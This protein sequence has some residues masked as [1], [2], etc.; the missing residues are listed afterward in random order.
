MLLKTGEGLYGAFDLSI[1][2]NP[3]R[4]L[5]Y[6]HLIHGIKKFKLYLSGYFLYRGG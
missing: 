5:L 4:K 6:Y 2:S 3:S 1:F